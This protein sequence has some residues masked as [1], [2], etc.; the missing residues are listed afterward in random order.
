MHYRLLALTAILLT[1][2]IECNNAADIP[3][4]ENSDASTT[5]PEGEEPVLPEEGP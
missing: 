1:A 3:S 2:L 4:N 5:V